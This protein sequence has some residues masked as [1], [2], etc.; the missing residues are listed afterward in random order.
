[1][2]QALFEVDVAHEVL[3]VACHVRRSAVV[4]VSVQRVPGLAAAVVDCPCLEEAAVEEEPD[5]ARVAHELVVEELDRARVVHE[6]AVDAF[7]VAAAERVPSA[8]AV[9]GFVAVVTHHGLDDLLG[10]QVLGWAALAGLSLPR[11]S[12]RLS[13]REGPRIQ[14]GQSVI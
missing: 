5:R 10:D 9:E 2:R 3:D 8:A 1:M 12:Q 4:V 14:M 7:A 13:L 11:Q 6:L